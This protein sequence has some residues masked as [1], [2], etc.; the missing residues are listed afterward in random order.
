MVIKFTKRSVE[1][2]SPIR[3]TA[4]AIGFDLTAISKS[5]VGYGCIKYDTGI[6]T[7][8]PKG[9]VGLL[10]PRSS[11]YK[12]ACILANCVGVIDNDYRGTIQFVYYKTDKSIED[13]D[14]KE[15]IGQIVFIKVDEIELEE[16]AELDETERGEGGFGSTGNK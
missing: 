13:Y 1:A 8:I 4:G 5:D 2:E 14:L 3:T 16:V 12:H 9:Y 15:R 10:F 11:S 7:A 6:A